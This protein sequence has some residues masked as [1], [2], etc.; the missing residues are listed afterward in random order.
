MNRSPR[1]VSNALF[2][3]AFQY[4]S[5]SRTPSPHPKRSDSIDER[6]LDS[7]NL[8]RQTSNTYSNAG[9]FSTGSVPL[10]T[11]SRSPSPYPRSRSSAVQSE[12]E[13]D[14]YDNIAPETPIFASARI[15][16]R[17]TWKGWLKNGGFGAWLFE[18]NAGWQVYVGFLILFLGGTGFEVVMLNR[19]I[20]IT[21]VYKFPYPLTTTLLQFTATHI[22]L[23][24]TAALTRALSRPLRSLGLS[25]AI[26]PYHHN[27]PSSSS[28]LRTAFHLPRLLTR[29]RQFTLE[30]SGIAGGG[31]LE[32]EW[33]TAKQVLPL[34]VI[35]VAKIVLSNISF[36]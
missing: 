2:Q 4:L 10:I 25:A 15:G 7:P 18:T 29:I 13:D 1:T 33:R 30:N 11:L 17:R 9:D 22:L 21:G 34:A 16:E 14:E 6:Y 28:G 26:A 32:F 27:S 3:P 35:F 23:L 5:R 31:L 12:D 19:I 24:L 8:S 36:A 20:L